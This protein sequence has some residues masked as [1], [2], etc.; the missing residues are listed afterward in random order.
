MPH[1]RHALA[2]S[3]AAAALCAS[4]LAALAHEPSKASPATPSSQ[5]PKAAAEAARAVDGFHAA[6]RAGDTRAA[7][8][9]LSDTALIYEAGGAERSKAAYAS[10]HL[11]ADAAFEASATE[12]PLRRTG[13]A[14]GDLAW[15]ATE[16]RVQA[17]TG[18]KLTDRLTTETAI[19]RRTPAGWRIEHVHWSSRA[20]APKP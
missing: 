14:S 15:I 11:A 2:A 1:H 10:E 17:K 3:L 6:L 13:G 19:L 5:L 12:M 16:G 7:L 8:G 4:P 9:F 18:E 20:A